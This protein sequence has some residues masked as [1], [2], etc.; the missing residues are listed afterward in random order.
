M[1]F[2]EILGLPT[3]ARQ[4]HRVTKKD[5]VAQWEQSAPA[6]ARLL[7]RTISWAAIVGVLSPT[8]VG[9]AAVVSEDV[10]VDMIPV[11]SVV[12]AENVKPADRKRVAE[13]LHRSM[14]RLAVVGLQAADIEPVL[15][16]ALSRLSRTDV[17]MSVLEA[18]LL[19]P[20]AAVAA[21]ALEV[22]HLARTDLVVL[23]R[24]LVRTAAANGRP[25]KATLGAV[26]AV[27]L[28]HRASLLNGD[29]AAVVRDAAREKSMQK[30]IELNA[31]AREVRARIAAVLAELYAERDDRPKGVPGDTQP[32]AETTVAS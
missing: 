2:A 20:V 14:P 13:L 28:R 29:L 7:G 3:R 9:A 10:R 32:A 5:I 31:R 26:E 27:E 30:R 22:G 21:H 15:S 25:A 18:H 16:L 12:L 6:D 24:D 4:M 17:G 1:D 11:L 19:V 8:T 23:Y